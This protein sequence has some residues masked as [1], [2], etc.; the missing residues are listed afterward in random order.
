M[1]ARWEMRCRENGPLKSSILFGRFTRAPSKSIRDLS[2][3][4][5]IGYILFQ[6]IQFLAQVINAPLQ[7]IADGEHPQ[8]FAIAIGNRK[9]AKVAVNHDSEGFPWTCLRRGKLHWS[10]HG[11]AN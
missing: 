1:T 9:M 10:S 8:Q 4:P 7:Y 3:R 11:I 5:I 6:C 2:A